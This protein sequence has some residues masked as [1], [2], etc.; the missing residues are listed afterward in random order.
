M[1]II[2]CLIAYLR[3][4]KIEI[5]FLNKLNTLFLFS[6]P[7]CYPSIEASEEGGGEWEILLLHSVQVILAF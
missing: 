6:F 1:K 4:K 2:T 7:F 3:Q 5:N